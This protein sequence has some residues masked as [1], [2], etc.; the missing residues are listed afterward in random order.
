MEYIQIPGLKKYLINKNG[1]VWSL[2]SNK[3]L[4]KTL[5]SSGY[6]TVSIGEFP[7]QPNYFIHRLVAITFIPNPENKPFVNHKD[8]NKLNHSIENLEWVTRLEN[9]RHAF[10]TGLYDSCMK[11]VRCIET[12][13]E[14]KSISSAGK[15]LDIFPGSITKQIQG[16]RH[17]AGGFTFEV[18]NK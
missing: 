11:A 2:L 9:V 6:L 17:T 16:K 15:S 4:K 8:G 12:G 7:E 14:Y 3:V 18:I 1:D 10:R 5:S 13:I